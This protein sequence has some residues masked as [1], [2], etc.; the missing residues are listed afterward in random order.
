MIYSEGHKQQLS[1]KQKEKKKKEG[2]FHI[3]LWPVR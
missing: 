1:H 2:V 3:V